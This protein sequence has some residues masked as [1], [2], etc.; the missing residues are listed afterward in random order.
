[1]RFK[2]QNYWMKNDFG[3]LNIVKRFIR[4]ILYIYLNKNKDLAR[5]WL[6]PIIYRIFR[7]YPYQIFYFIFYDIIKKED[8]HKLIWEKVPKLD[9]YVCWPNQGPEEKITKKLRLA[10]S[11]DFVPILKFK[12]RGYF[13]Y[14]FTEESLI[15][16]LSNYK[17]NLPPSS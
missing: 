11:K 1:M 7:I 10:L 12:W 15:N 17:S 5:L 9:K 6:S 13:D 2:L 4:R 16:K 14:Q 8:E 3:E